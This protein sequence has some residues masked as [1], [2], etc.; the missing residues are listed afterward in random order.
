MLTL[1][2]CL[3]MSVVLSTLPIPFT[4]LLTV[5][6]MYILQHLVR[7]R[8]WRSERQSLVIRHTFGNQ[9]S[10][11]EL[12]FYGLVVV[13]VS[14]V[15]MS[16][17]PQ[18]SSGARFFFPILPMIAVF[19]ALGMV[20]VADSGV[21]ALFG[22]LYSLSILTDSREMQVVV[23]MHRVILGL[24]ALSHCT[25]ILISKNIATCRWKLYVFPTVMLLLIL[26]TPFSKLVSYSQ[27]ISRY[28]GYPD[29][30]HYT[31]IHDG[32]RWRI[33]NEIRPWLQKHVNEE[34]RVLSHHAHYIAW[35]AGTGLRGLY[36]SIYLPKDP[37]EASAFLSEKDL[38]KLDVDYIVQ[39]NPYLHKYADRTQ[40]E[41]WVN[42]YNSLA[43]RGDLQEVY[44]HES[45]LGELESYIFRRAGN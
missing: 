20:A 31:E 16:F 22:V 38:T 11:I 45:P 44:L 19:G 3:L 34:D 14:V 6:G 21:L 41:A 24:V 32:I 26:T 28:M 36:N 2:F 5:A 30:P 23:P 1:C 37:R 35:S 7:E 42:V 43:T 17:D 40:Y 9:S 18:I 27:Q 15:N 25:Y 39:I 29:D 4:G 10:G 12:T 13:C 33:L 8:F